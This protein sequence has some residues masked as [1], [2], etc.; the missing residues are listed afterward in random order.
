MTD[1]YP[2]SFNRL[3]SQARLPTTLPSQ[4]RAFLPPLLLL[5]SFL[6]CRCPPP[7]PTAVTLRVKNT[8]RDG[9]LVNDTKGQLG[10]TLQRSVNGQWFS[11]DDLPCAC[12]SCDRICERSCQCPDAG[13][14]GIVRQVSPNGQAD[15]QW[16]G[17]IQVAGFAC[18]DVCLV[19]ENAPPDET[20]RLQL[21]FVNQI[22]G[23][24]A[25]SDGGRV[26]APFPPADAQTCVTREFQPQ[27]GVVEISPQRG[28]DCTTTADCKGKDELCLSG[29]C[30]AGCPSNVYPAQPELVVAYTSMGF[31]AES[32]ET[33]GGRVLQTGTGKITATQFTG[34]TLQVTVSN[35]GGS[36][37]VDVKL[38][39]GLGG[40]SLTNNT[41]VKVL[42]AVRTDD[43][44]ISRG[45][46]LRDAAT[47]ELLFAADS[48]LIAPVLKDA[49][50]APFT[51]TRE[52]GAV[53]CRIDASC[54]KLVFSKQKLTNGTSSVSVEPGKLASLIGGTNYRFWNVTD[55]QYGTGS[56]CRSYRPYA[57]WKER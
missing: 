52:A 56:M 4:M 42:V 25:P 16:T 47:N 50:L 44:V 17:V 37:R 38:P 21:C 31:F 18:N 43:N 34:E 48:A 10:L 11:F 40:P 24:E 45:V 51:V 1:K 14:T 9:L 41:D 19:P 57:F 53:G 46:T 33:D 5:S 54:G 22:D 2:V 8:T 29:S 30:T 15:R 49:D 35:V 23:V 32:R 36:G 39:G 7:T 6:G 27:Q 55:G 12:Q 3:P 20:F 26:S 13:I 28:A